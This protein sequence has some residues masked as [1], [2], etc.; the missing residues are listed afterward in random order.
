LLSYRLGSLMLLFVVVSIPL[1]I[2]TNRAQTQRAAVKALRE[3]GFDVWYEFEKEGD[4]FNIGPIAD[5]KPPGPTWLREWL[6]IDYVARV[7]WL[8]EHRPRPNRPN[9]EASRVCPRAREH[10]AGSSDSPAADHI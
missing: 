10:P 5:P 8:P 1:A 3:A 6:G 2:V 9:R 7:R 4:G